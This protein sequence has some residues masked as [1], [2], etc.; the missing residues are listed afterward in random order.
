M[1]RD[2]DSSIRKYARVIQLIT[3]ARC[4]W[5]WTG[6][7]AAIVAFAQLPAIDGTRQLF[8][9]AEAGGSW[10]ISL[11]GSDE[12]PMLI[13]RLHREADVWKLVAALLKSAFNGSQWMEAMRAS[14]LDAQG[15]IQTSFADML[16]AQQQAQL[17]MWERSGWQRLTRPEQSHAWAS[18]EARFAYFTTGEKPAHSVTWDLEPFF[19]SDQIDLDELE[20]DFVVKFLA[21]LRGTVE[22]H[23]CVYSLVW[24]TTCYRFYPQNSRLDAYSDY[25]AISPFPRADSC[26]FIDP[27][28][29]FGIFAKRKSWICVFG[30]PLVN[31]L[32]ATHPH[33]LRYSVET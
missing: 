30:E 26:Y 10:F 32:M 27:H 8:S 28:G 21:A 1:K 15:V 24:D 5:E 20:S 29:Q 25:W 22:P 2:L 12:T 19:D 7:W 11:P 23:G 9:V 6:A 16:D 31:A 18:M 17:Q 4:Q 14:M 3:Q 33:A 13:G